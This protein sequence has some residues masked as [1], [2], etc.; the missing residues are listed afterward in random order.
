MFRIRRAIV[1]QSGRV[2]E[3]LEK[4]LR[5]D[6]KKYLQENIVTIRDNRYVI[7]VK[8]EYRSQV[9][10]LLHDAS[11]SGATVFIEPV[12]VV[13]ANNEIRILAAK[14]REEI[15]RILLELSSLAADCSKELIN[16]YETIISL[17]VYFAKASYA[18]EL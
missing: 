4:L 17:D 6:V 8:A 5:S 12:S 13:E 7:P 16:N 18:I 10:G 15:D 11:A 9:P 1:R 14:E 2:K 3:S